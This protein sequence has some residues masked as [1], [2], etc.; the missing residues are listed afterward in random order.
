MLGITFKLVNATDYYQYDKSYNVYKD[1]TDDQKYMKNL[2]QN[3]EDIKIVGVVQPTESASATMLK[4]G[5]G[6]PAT[7]TTHV[8]EQAKSSEIVQK[9]LENTNIDIFTGKEFSSK[10]NNKLDMN[11]L[12]TVDAKMLQKAFTFD[13][14]KLKFDMGNLDLSQLQL[15]TSTLPALDFNSIFKDMKINISQEQV[16]AM[17]Q[18]IMT[19]FQQYVK[20]NGFTNPDEMNSYF[21]KYLQ[22]ESAQSLIQSEM[23]KLLQESGLTEQFQTQ[24]QKQMQTI[25][26]QYMSTI[27]KSMQEQIS[28]QMTKQMGS[29]AASMQ[30]AIKIDASAF[31]KAIKMNMDTDELSELMMSLMTTETSSYDGNLK[32]LGYA[33]FDKP[34]GINI[35]PKDFE[36]KQKVIDIL[37]NYNEDMKKVDEDKVISYTDYVGTLMSSVTDI[38]NVISYVL[39]A[40]VAIS[41]VVSSIM[42][43]VITYISVLER[44]KEIGILRAIGASKKNIS[45]VFNAETFIIGLLA[46]VLGIVITL[47]LLIPSNMLIHEIAGNVDVSATLPVAGGVIL[48]VLSVILTLIGGLI[49]S[50]KAAQ[51]DPVTAL[52]TE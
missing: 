51:E 46:G 10:E 1:K 50:K 34:S 22:T 14:S 29:L 16:N 26:A 17:S 52:R 12:F 48:I 49:P 39:I 31:G 33:D 32:N 36:N 9:Q 13:Q 41:L 28:A 43:G 6:Y 47:I 45:Q 20:D 2:I 24:L 21:M 44:K 40:F 4:T 8:I 37:D 3:G 30:D 19:Q 5:I 15:D 42:I 7:L 27:T 25:M 38:I 23:T 35:Y 11:S 18:N